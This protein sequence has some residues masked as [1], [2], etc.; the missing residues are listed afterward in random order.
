[1]GRVEEMTPC[2][3]AVE[4]DLDVVLQAAQAHRRAVEHRGYSNSGH[5]LG[6]AQVCVN[7]GQLCRSQTP[8]PMELK[9]YQSEV[10]V[11]LKFL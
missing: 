7:P 10:R 9:R 4:W 3:K 11:E 2:P 8:M 6:G 1:M 5:S